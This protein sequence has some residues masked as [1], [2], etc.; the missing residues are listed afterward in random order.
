MIPIWLKVAAIVII[1]LLSGFFV[2][3]VIQK[4]YY[5]GVQNEIIVPNGE[6]TQII[7]SDGTKV[8]LNAGTHLKYP[9]VFS[10]KKR[11]V[12]LIGEAFFDV[13]KDKSIPFII[14]TLRF[15]VKVTGTSFNLKLI[16]KI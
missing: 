1:T 9:A 5:A 6:K 2:N 15:D 11:E 12:T 16:R 10:R 8:Y 13:A 4:N 7:L 14:K 3:Q